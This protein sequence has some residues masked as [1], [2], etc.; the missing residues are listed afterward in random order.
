MNRIRV[1]VLAALAVAGALTI[2]GALFAQQRPQQQQTKTPN[3]SMYQATSQEHVRTFT[4]TVVKEGDTLVLKLES[5][6]RYYKLDD[7]KKAEPFEGK[8]VKVTGT[9]DASTNTIN[10]QTIEPA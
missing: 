4:G 2:A 10:I 1:S 9:L 7:P 6:K 5:S 3:T 8:S